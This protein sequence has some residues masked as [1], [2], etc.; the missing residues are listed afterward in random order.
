VYTLQDGRLTV[1]DLSGSVQGTRDLAA[2]AQ[3][4]DAS[5]D[6][7]LYTAASRLHLLRLT[8]GKDDTLRLPGQFLRAWARFSADGGILYA[9]N[10]FAP[11]GYWTGY[12]PASAVNALLG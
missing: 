12:A 10:A 7:V 9:Y 11:Q 5:G 6:L 2:G 4:E 8:D 3:L 1:R